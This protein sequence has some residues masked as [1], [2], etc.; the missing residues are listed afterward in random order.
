MGYYLYLD[1]VSTRD[2]SLA[3]VGCD[4]IIKRRVVK[5]G[6]HTE[7][8]LSAVMSFLKE[9]VPAGIIIAQ[10][11]GSFSQTRIICVVANALAYAWQ[12]KLTTVPINTNLEQ[13]SKNM[14][15]F[16]WSKLILPKYSGPGVGR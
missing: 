6:T 12:I 11:T 3:L 8:L 16:K 2:L 4:K 13:I 1:G 14:R 9:Q 10:G 7:Y 15:H 5:E